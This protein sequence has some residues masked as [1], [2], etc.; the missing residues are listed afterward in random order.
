MPSP[1]PGMDPYLEAPSIWPDLHHSL[2]A[3][4][5]AAGFTLTMRHARP[6][7]HDAPLYSL[8]SRG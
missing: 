6:D 7:K 5:G 2:A 8:W 4:L 3:E 1:F